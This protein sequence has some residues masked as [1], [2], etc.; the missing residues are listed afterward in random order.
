[1]RVL[2]DVT[3]LMERELT[4]VG[5]Y[6]KNLILRLQNIPGL[7][8]EGALYAEKFKKKKLIANHTSVPLIPYF[9]YLSGFNLGKYD[10][11]HGP[12]YKIPS[13]SFYK[14]VVTI[15]DLVDYESTIIDKKRAEYGIH[16]F[17]KMLFKARPD[18]II[19]VSDFTRNCLLSRFPQFEEIT[20]TVYLGVDHIDV[21]GKETV[22]RSFPYPYLLFVGTNDKRKN[23]VKAVEA[24][25]ICK[26]TIKNI[27]LVVVGK[28]GYSHE[29]ADE[30]INASRYAEHIHR[31]GFI[32]NE[33]LVRLYRHAEVFVFP[34][35]YEGFGIPI[36]EAMKLGCPVVTSNIG[37]MKEIS[38]NAAMLVSPDDAEDIAQQII[39]ICNDSALRA[40]LIYSG[41]IRSEQ[42][43]WS[44]CAEETTQVYRSL[45]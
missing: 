21:L 11:F 16:K 33:G 19:T 23:L 13:G 34:S 20:K 44:K 30:K 42:F 27:H 4:G 35:L 25:E 10:I 9:R 28:N 29:M 14:K 5:I 37:A 43:S 15:H 39:T 36:L 3:S 26:E 6:V 31:L 40:K 32:D 18:M 2:M 1:M 24:F 22:E 45:L 7:D 17:E 38:G 41:R 8:I 12:D